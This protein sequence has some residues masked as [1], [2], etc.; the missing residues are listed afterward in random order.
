M[1]H[2]LVAG[3][4]GFIGTHLVKRLLDEKQRVTVV[5]NLSTG[6]LDNL[7]ERFSDRNLFVDVA[8]IASYGG[9]RDIDYVVNLACPASPV[10]YQRLPIETILTNV[11]GVE[12]LIHIAMRSHAI[13]LQSSTSEV[14]GDPLKHP[15][16]EEYLGNVNCYGPRS[17]L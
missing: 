3:G 12:N 5:D 10:H 6:S 4:A 16:T 2:Y 1:K 13:F 15:Q 11:V 17:L 14:Y 7:H 8:D 9:D